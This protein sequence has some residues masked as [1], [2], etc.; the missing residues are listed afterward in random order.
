MC[1]LSRGMNARV[2]A[3]CSEKGVAPR[4]QVGQ[5]SLNVA[6]Y[7]ALIRLPLPACEGLTVIFDL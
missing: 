5:R 6:L 4:F 1:D 7:R 2:G 3:A